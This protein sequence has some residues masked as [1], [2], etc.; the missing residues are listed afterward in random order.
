M[1]F[2]YEFQEQ[3]STLPPHFKL[4]L[5]LETKQSTFWKSVFNLKAPAVY[6]NSLHLEMP[7]FTYAIRYEM[8]YWLNEQALCLNFLTNIKPVSFKLTTNNRF[9]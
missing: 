2:D 4:K 6:Y 7:E 5:D 8:V 3:R 9:G 1:K